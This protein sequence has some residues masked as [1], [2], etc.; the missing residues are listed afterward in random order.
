[1]C[2]VTHSPDGPSAHANNKCEIDLVLEQGKP[3]LAENLRMK[4]MMNR[5]ETVDPLSVLNSEAYD[6]AREACRCRVQ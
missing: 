3:K 6:E 2:C 1:M 5:R 4:N